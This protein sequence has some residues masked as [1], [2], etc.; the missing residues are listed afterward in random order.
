MA[1]THAFVSAI[2]DGADETVVRP[3][4]WNAAHTGTAA[5]DAHHADHEF[6]GTDVMSITDLF[7]NVYPSWFKDWRDTVGFTE[8]HTGTGA[9][10]VGLPYGTADTG[11]TQD[12]IQSHHSTIPWSVYNNIAGYNLRMTV[13]ATINSVV[14]NSTVWIG[15][16]HTPEAPSTTQEHIGWKILNGAVWATVGDGSTEATADTGVAYTQYAQH[17]LYFKQIQTTV[18]FYV[19]KALKATL[20]TNTPTAVGVYSTYYIS[21]QDTTAKN[22]VIYPMWMYQGA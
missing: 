16:F 5:P 8:Y 15:Y 9:F 10:T 22:L 12:S 19:D 14:T 20:T 2:E 18:Y 7:L 6:G 4:N 11:I 17:D 13:R 3:S 1:I 21:T